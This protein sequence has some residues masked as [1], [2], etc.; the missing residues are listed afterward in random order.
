M[1]EEISSAYVMRTFSI[2]QAK[3]YCIH[4]S[5]HTLCLWQQKLL[6]KIIGIG[7][8]SCMFGNIRMLKHSAVQSV[9]MQLY[10]N[11]VKLLKNPA[12]TMLIVYLRSQLH[13]LKPF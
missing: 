6:F 7:N 4:T 13:K 2:Q 12:V 11:K 8:H 5:T 1:S 3:V 10:A 9:I